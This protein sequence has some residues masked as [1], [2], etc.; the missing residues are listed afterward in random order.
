MDVGSGIGSVTLQLAKQYTALDLTLQDL[1]ER[2]YQAKNEVWPR[3]CPEALAEGRVHF[4]AI[5]FFTQSPIPG[6]D[7][8]YVRL[9]VDN[10]FKKC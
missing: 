1:P 8:Y 10:L 5:D 6:A 7:I 3:E 9:L 2:M 4:Q